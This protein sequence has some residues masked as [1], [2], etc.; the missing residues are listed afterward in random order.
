M[1]NAGRLRHRVV[2]QRPVDTRD[3]SDGS[4]IRTWS[5]LA[6][7][8]AAIEPLSAKEFIASQAE[9]SQV[10][11]R[12]VIRYRDDISHE[13][14]L[15]HAAKDKYYNIE[16]ILSDKD[17]GLEYIT[18][19]CSEGVRYQEGPETTPVVLTSPVVTGTAQVGEVIE[20]SNGTWANDP[21]TYT[22][23]WHRGDG[24][25]IEGADE[26]TYLLTVA[27]EDIDVY[28]TVT[29]TNTAGSA[30]ANSA[31]FGPVIPE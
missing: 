3:S 7:V 9:D 1:L 23:Q 14:R 22:Y 19:P 30:S 18:I 8:W 27:E 16:G 4:V 28:C 25:E 24:E 31:D 13:M 12:I 10:S 2:I 17:S 21:V 29:A 20:V 15:Y 6:T 5:N 11:T 26:D